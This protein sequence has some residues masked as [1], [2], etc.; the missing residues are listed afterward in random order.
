[1][2]QMGNT[3]PKVKLKDMQP[4]VGALYLQMEKNEDEKLDRNSCGKGFFLEQPISPP[5]A[6][7]NTQNSKKGQDARW[8]AKRVLREDGG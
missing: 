3:R 7:F 5:K 1:M 2:D 8:F 6:H 4:K